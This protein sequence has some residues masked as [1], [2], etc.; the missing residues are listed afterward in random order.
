MVGYDG[1]SFGKLRYVPIPKRIHYQTDI[2]QKLKEILNSLKIDFAQFFPIRGTKLELD[3]AI[4]DKKICIG[5]DGSYWHKN[6]NK[7]RRRDY[8]LKSLGWKTIRFSDKEIFD[9]ELSV[10][11]KILEEIKCKKQKLG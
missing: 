7:D 11:R 10:K 2:E 3:F 9:N 5:A 6:K 1:L 4:P 8:F